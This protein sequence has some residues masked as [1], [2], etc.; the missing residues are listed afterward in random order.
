M[1]RITALD[2][3]L[4]ADTPI[5]ANGSFWMQHGVDVELRGDFKAA[6]LTLEKATR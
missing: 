6:A 1:Y 3:K 2:G 4:S 5:A